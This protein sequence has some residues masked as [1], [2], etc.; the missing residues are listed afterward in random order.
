MWDPSRPAGMRSGPDL[1]LG[2]IMWTQWVRVCL[3]GVELKGE[4]S[5]PKERETRGMGKNTDLL[6]RHCKDLM[7]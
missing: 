2:C 5:I 4:F 3:E 1:G 7:Q 6:S